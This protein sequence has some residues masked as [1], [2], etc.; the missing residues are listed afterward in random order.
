MQ[1]DENRCH[2]NLKEKG[3][4]FKGQLRAYL[5]GLVSVV[6]DEAMAMI[7]EG[8]DGSTKFWWTVLLE[9][10]VEKEFRNYPLLFKKA[11]DAATKAKTK[12]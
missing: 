4:I 2:W 11:F 7:K 10:N 5:D 1:R 6:D 12:V 8:L 9:Q 3:S